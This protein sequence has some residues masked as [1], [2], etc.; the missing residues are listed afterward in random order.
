MIQA[1]A[2]EAGIILILGIVLYF[3][4]KVCRNLQTEVKDLTCENSELKHNMAYL[5][6][7]AEELAEIKNN[8]AKVQEDIHNAKTD[9]EVA[10]IINA[11][12]HVNNS[13]L[14]QQ[15]EG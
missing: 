1:I 4:A 10:D 5:V 8:E 7:H 11:I 6:T 3:T 15:A 9:E 12:V 14:R 2:I 13:K